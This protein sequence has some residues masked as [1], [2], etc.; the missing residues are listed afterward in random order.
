MVR[1]T[2]NWRDGS[3]QHGFGFVVGE[4]DDELYIVTADHVVRGTL[5]DELAETIILTF[6]SHQGQEFQ[7]K[8]LGTHD[9]D[10]DVAVLL[11]E[12]P[13]GFQLKP[14]IMR[15]SQ[16]GSARA[17]DPGLVCRPVGSLVRALDARAR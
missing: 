2:A 12:R 13:G 4:R 14:E 3:T 16:R 17:R 7:A 10:R 1:I 8:L 15:R 9:A 11:A 5:P 6:F